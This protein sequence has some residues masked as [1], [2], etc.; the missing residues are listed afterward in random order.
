[1][2]SHTQTE[3]LEKVT[4]TEPMESN[5]YTGSKPIFVEP[6]RTLHIPRH[7]H[8]RDPYD[9][10]SPC[11]FDSAQRFEG[12]RSNITNIPFMPLL[13]ELNCKGSM[14]L[15][16]IQGVPLV[17]YMNCAWCLKLPKLPTLH[18]IKKLV[19]AYC[20]LLTEL[21]EMPFLE[22][23]DCTGCISLKELPYFPKLTRLTCDF[24]TIDQ[25]NLVHKLQ[26]N[27]N[28]YS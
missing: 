26:G 11:E 16:E 3:P 23:L 28:I 15:V 9:N 4:H 21:P 24:L 7:Y 10:I 5:S 2:D 8:C 13:Q 20:P 19:C 17:T 27:K 1:M 12:V 14:K 18:S 25:Y 6:L 22:E